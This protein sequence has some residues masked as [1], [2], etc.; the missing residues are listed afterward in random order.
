MLVIEC[1]DCGPRNSSEFGYQ[2][3]IRSRPKGSPTEVAWRQYLY[4]EDNFS[5]F[6]KERWFH[7]DGCRRFIDVVRHTV[8]NEIQ[9]VDAVGRP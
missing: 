4:E 1:P 2:G 8:T 6:S 7:A 5:G 9:S 3:K